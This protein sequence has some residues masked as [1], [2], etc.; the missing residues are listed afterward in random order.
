MG[1]FLTYMLLKRLAILILMVLDFFNVAVDQAF[2]LSLTSFRIVV[3][4]ELVVPFSNILLTIS[5]IYC[6]FILNYYWMKDSDHIH[7]A[8][9]CVDIYIIFYVGTN[10]RFILLIDSL[11]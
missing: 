9:S 7:V 4:E 11:I 8:I 6:S 3:D 5:F 1:K 10:C 2:S